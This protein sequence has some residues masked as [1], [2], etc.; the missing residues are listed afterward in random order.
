MSEVNDTYTAL[1]AEDVHN[2]TGVADVIAMNE[3]GDKPYARIEFNDGSI[4]ATGFEYDDESGEMDGW[5]AT[6]YS[7]PDDADFRE[8]M[9]Q[10][11]GTEV[12]GMLEWIRKLSLEVDNV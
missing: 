1:V 7:S 3:P 9:E 6:L 4:L 2:W 5:S 8:Y 12:S 10:D 11:G